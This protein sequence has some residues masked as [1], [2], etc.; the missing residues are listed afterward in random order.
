MAPTHLE[1][2]LL[3]S[4]TAPTAPPTTAFELQDRGSGGSGG[5]S[6]RE[7]ADERVRRIVKHQSESCLG[8]GPIGQPRAVIVSHTNDEQ[9]AQPAT[10]EDRGVRGAFLC[11]G[12]IELPLAFA[13]IKREET[14]V[15]VVVHA[16]VHPGCEHGGVPLAF[17][18]TS[19]AEAESWEREMEE[20]TQKVSG[21]HWGVS[22]SF[23]RE[24][25][26]RW[27]AERLQHGT[28]TVAGYFHDI[29]LG[30]VFDTTWQWCEAVLSG[31]EAQED[32]TAGDEKALVYYSSKVEKSELYADME[33]TDYMN[34]LK[35]L[36]LAPAGKRLSYADFIAGECDSLGRE[37]VG[38]A[39]VFVSHVWKM[40]AKDFFEVCLAEMSDDDYAWIDLY[41]HNQYQGAVSTIGDENSMYWVRK[42]GELVGGIGKVI[43]VVTD[44]EAPVMLTRIWCLFELNAA[45]DTGAELN[46]VAS[47]AQQRDLSMH[48]NEKFKQLEALVNSIDV[49][50]CDAKRPHELQD[51]SIFLNTL[52]G[53]EDEV[54]AK[55]QREMLR[56]LCKAAE[57]V[58]HRTNPQRP[59]LSAAEMDLETVEIGPSAARLTWMLERC[60]WLAS[61]LMMMGVVSMLLAVYGVAVLDISDVNPGPCTA[62]S[63]CTTGK[64]CSNWKL[65]HDCGDIRHG[66]CDVIECPPEDSCELNNC[67]NST[68][69]L[70]SCSPKIFPGVADVCQVQGSFSLVEE[71]TADS[72]Y[73][74]FVLAIV[75]ITLLF[76][77]ERFVKHQSVRQLR[78]PPACGAWATRHYI[79]IKAAVFFIA[80]LIVPTVLWCTS[81]LTAP[82]RGL[83]LACVA[84]MFVMVAVCIPLERAIAAT[85]AGASLCVKSGWLWLRLGDV[86]R[87]VHIFETAQA[88]LLS[89]V[90]PN[91]VRWSWIAAAGH[92]RAL[93]QAGR[94]EEAEAVRQQVETVARQQDTLGPARR[95]TVAATDF[96]TPAIVSGEQQG[97]WFLLRATLAAAVRAP[98]SEVLRLLAEAVNSSC[99]VPAGSWPVIAH[100][101]DKEQRTNTEGPLLPEWNDF[102][103]RMA[104]QN[105]GDE[106]T[107]V[108]QEDQQ[109]WEAYR[110]ATIACLEQRVAKLTVYALESALQS[111]GL[112]PGRSP[113]HHR[114]A[115]GERERTEAQLLGNFFAHP[116]WAYTS[117]AT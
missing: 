85:T 34:L 12:D 25:Y 52:R 86:T 15:T 112:L 55:L 63:N 108:T 101:M 32:K 41:L 14:T 5:G 47:A 58:I 115:D 37:K 83:P 23:I 71:L 11:C 54:N 102:L 80:V 56:W 9:A 45:I 116:A 24:Q 29:G 33:L 96:L 40:T 65:C 22:K 4:S 62:H 75:A 74:G 16:A 99:W 13:T 46:F 17:I 84:G 93:C 18:C 39:T 42:F 64:Y 8:E 51:K 81:M 2:N 66:L 6:D 53:V 114:L 50:K 98:D 79:E 26:D 27:E 20:L 44:W 109:T 97:L 31:L 92:A 35:S 70:Y 73:V 91:A 43:A 21:R 104:R 60:P 59:V 61:G 88:Q 107:S 48:L 1:A 30:S 89:I 69:F 87:A 111:R 72:D 38:R 90:G 7:P 82:V 67:C 10:L 94:Q 110:T 3:A 113:S 57:A 77:G 78:T 36:D 106:A 103:D 95:F 117:Q 76:L 68:E 28:K 105:E 49:R 100:G 19:A